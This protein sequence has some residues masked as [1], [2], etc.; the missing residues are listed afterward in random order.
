MDYLVKLGTEKDSEVTERPTNDGIQS[1]TYIHNS[2]CSNG[3][4]SLNKVVESTE[5]L[6]T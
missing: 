4:F 6:F 1:R 5:P 3:V 2:W